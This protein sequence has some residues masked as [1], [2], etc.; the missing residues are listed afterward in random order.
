MKR[1]DLLKAVAASSAATSSAAAQAPSG[2]PNIL[3][4]CTDQQRYDTIQGL[5]N[6]HIRTPNLQL[7]MDTATVFTHAFVQNPV[8]SPSRASFLTGRYPH[9]TGLRANGQK[10]RSSERLITRTL[11]DQGYVCGLAG[12]LHLSPCAGGRVEDRIDDGY[13][14]FWWSHDIQDAWPGK[15]R[16][17]ESLRASGVAWPKPPA[18]T[19]AWGVPIDPKHSQT[20]WCADRAVEFIQAQKQSRPWLMSVNMYQPHHPFYPTAEYFQRYDPEKLPDP[21]YV[22]GELDNKPEYQRRDAAGAP[23]RPSFENTD[24]LTRRK[25]TA[26][27][28]AMIEEIDDQFGRILKT[29]E[30]TGQAENTIVIFM[31]DHGEMLGDHGIYHKGPY[32]Y[33]CGMRVPLMIRWP[34]RYRA[35]QKLDA[36]VEMVDLAPTLLEAAGL[37]PSPGIQGRSLTGL[38]EGKTTGHRDSVYMENYV[39]RMG[40]TKPVLATAL[41]TRTH[42]LAIYHSLGAGELYDL[43]RDP[44]EVRNLWDDSAHRGI[45]EELTL[46]LM[47]RM[48]D[49][50][51]PLPPRVAP[52]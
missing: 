49:T 23:N 31:S 7:F 4:V 29:L 39:P 8:C 9:V 11:A 35:G 17:R 13:R 38:L 19:P 43:A 52:W 24:A 16:W 32:F 12:K 28:Y 30:D 41:R 45:R 46:E 14:H 21:A 47:K 51:D 34:G 6:S 48:T 25:I 37:E 1:R 36:L 44:G 20:H 18:N 26:A 15:N 2:R 27:Y 42:K 22:Q 3:W 50:L 33:D 40:A 5:N 10:I